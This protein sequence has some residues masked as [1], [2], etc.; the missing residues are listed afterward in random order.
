[1]TA[2]GST[3]HTSGCIM[4]AAPAI[5][6]DGFKVVP[7]LDQLLHDPAAT[8]LGRAVNQLRAKAVRRPSVAHPHLQRPHI[9]KGC[10]FHYLKLT[11]PILNSRSQS[12]SV[13]V[14]LAGSVMLLA[15]VRV[16]REVHR[17]HAWSRCEKTG[18]EPLSA[19][20]CSAEEPVSLLC[21]TLAPDA[22]SL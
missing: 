11:R 2:S 12:A 19:A 5:V 18:K 14:C 9:L 16:P 22:M 21:C 8:S 17:A 7:L 13:M 6:T 4:K 20:H 15:R 1:M 3:G 10:N